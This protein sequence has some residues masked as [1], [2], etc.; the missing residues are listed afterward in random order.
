MI[1]LTETEKQH[2][3][4]HYDSYVID[5]QE[6]VKPDWVSRKFPSGGRWIRCVE[7]NN[8]VII[9]QILG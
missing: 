4:E 5:E 3:L 9:K 7:S 2:L 6:T 8:T 1:E